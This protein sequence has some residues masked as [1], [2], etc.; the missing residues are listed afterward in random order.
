M[1]AVHPFSD[2][3]LPQL[4]LV[5]ANELESTLPLEHTAVTVRV[6]GRVA[7]V[8]VAQRFGN[9]INSAVE[10]DYLFPL[11]ED[12]AI[13]GFELRLGSRRVTGELHERKMANDAYEEA[14]SKGQRA[15]LMEQRRPNLYAVRLANVQPGEV[16]HAVVRYQQRVR[17]EDGVFEFIYPMGIT[18]KYE[19]PSRPGEGEGTHAPIRRADEP[20]GPVEI[21]V[22][23]D[24][25]VAFHQ[26]SSPTHPIEVVELDERRFHARLAGEQIPDRDFVLR[27]AAAGSQVQAAAW[28]SGLPGKE[29]FMS[30]LVPP[31]LEDDPQPYPREF[32]FVLDRS[33][34]MYGEPII[35][36]RNA[37]RA[38]LRS[39]NP[40]DSFYILLFD[41]KLEWFRHEA[42]SV[43]QE[44]VDLADRFLGEVEGRGGTEIVEALE[45]ALSLPADPERVR[46][47]IFLTD[48]AV[49][50]EARVLERIRQKVGAARLFTFGI[51]PSVNRALLNRMAAFGRGRASYLQLDEDIEGAVIRF[52]DSVSFPAITGLSLEWQHAKAWDVY[53]S[54]LPDLYYGQPLEVCGRL[55]RSGHAP[56]ELILRGQQGGRAVEIRA[57]VPPLSSDDLAVGRLW[58]QARVE[59]LLDQ[60]ALEPARTEQIRADILALAL[61]F[62]LLTALTSFVAVDQDS[63]SGGGQARVIHIAQPVPQDLTPAVFLPSVPMPSNTSPLPPPPAMMASYSISASA[64]I[65]RAGKS[66]AQ[67]LSTGSVPPTP[68]DAKQDLPDP[69]SREAVLRWLARTQQM[70]G[71]WQGSLE[72]T[73]AALLAFVRAGHTNRSGS[74]RQIIRKAVRWLVENPQPGEAGFMRAR[75]LEELA[76]A[77]Q[78]DSDRAAAHASRLVLGP[79]SSALE[80]AAL[81][82]EESAPDVIHT[83]ADLRLAVLLNVNRPLPVSLIRGKEAETALIWAAALP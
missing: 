48:G 32:V 6:T 26:I 77:T 68:S 31:A 46:F 28:A 45:A 73:A 29:Y 75:A 49:S 66:M 72:L 81:G 24:A 56:A 2:I 15:G 52:Q 43:S 23:V 39:L 59:D 65:K 3:T 70:D 64:Q 44:Q 17:V 62:N 7:T 69:D 16:V 13:T 12:A 61:E 47:V 51:G 8:A 78:N 5:D 19:S 33:G 67:D 25:G 80:R 21:E 79:P 10:L 63:Q 42:C 30:A 55:S 35:Q 11:P 14:R 60:Q 1:A 20:V 82:Q 58:A 57:V 40:T 41:D 22:S 4:V 38:C 83:L 27:F 37:L 34:S 50:A 74:F 18:P 54:R 36:A 53:P 76:A 9:P 71:S